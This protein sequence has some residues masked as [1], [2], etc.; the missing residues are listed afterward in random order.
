MLTCFLVVG[1]V[2]QHVRQL[3]RERLDLRSRVHVL[4]HRYRALLIV[5]HAVRAGDH[6]LVWHPQHLEPRAANLPGQPVPQPRGCFAFQQRRSGRN[7]QWFSVGLGGIPHVGRPGS[8]HPRAH[9]LAGLRRLPRPE[10]PPRARIGRGRGG[11][12]ARHGREDHVARLALH[13]LPTEPLPLPVPGNQGGEGFGH[14][15]CLERG[16][17]LHPDQHRVVERPRPEPRREGE[18]LP[19]VVTRDQRLD[20]AGQ[21][22]VQLVEL[23]L[24]RRAGV[25]VRCHAPASSSAGRAKVARGGTPDR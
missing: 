11:E 10:P 20:R 19:P 25:L 12:P 4:P 13:H 2:H 16:F 17:V 3:V 21:L 22:L 6:P 24:S 7:W 14:A 18:R 5:G 15:A 23:R 9:H 1:I 8:D